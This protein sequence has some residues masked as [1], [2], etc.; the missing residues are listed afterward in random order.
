ML[1]VHDIGDYKVSIAP[2]VADID[3]ADPEVFTLAD[4]AREVLSEYGRKFGFVIA[5]LKDSGTI[6]P[7]GYIHYLPP[8]NDSAYNMFIPTKHEHGDRSKLPEWDHLIYI[9]GK[10]R[11]RDTP[12]I[13]MADQSPY[14]VA[15]LRAGTTSEKMVERITKQVPELAGFLQPG[16]M[17][18]VEARGSLANIDLWA[19]V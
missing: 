9:G 13:G 11:L 1:E 10:G 17:T 14:I 16:P 7:L 4:N 15:N 18:R 2:T 6:S 5:S 19:G 3:R 8:N 12:K